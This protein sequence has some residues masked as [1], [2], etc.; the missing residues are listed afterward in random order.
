MPDG[1]RVTLG[2]GVL[3]VGDAISD[4]FTFF[5][6]QTSLG[7]GQWTVT[8]FFAGNPFGPAVEPGDFF[9]ATD[10]FV[11]FV[12]NFGEVDSITTSSVVASPAYTDA[13][14]DNQIDGTSGADVIDSGYTDAQGDSVDDGSGFGAG[15][16]GDYVRGGSGADD[17]SSGAGDDVVF[18]D[19]GNDTIDGGAGNDTLYGDG[20]VSAP[21]PQ[22]EFLDWSN[23]GGLGTDLSAGFTQTTGLMDLSVS[24]TIDGNNAPTFEVDTATN[25]TEAGEPFDTTSSLEMGG[26]GDAATS[27]TIIDFAPAT[28][29]TAEDEVQDVSF[30]I[31]DI[32]FFDGNHLDI[33][34]VD[35]FDADG[36]P[37]TVTLTPE[38]SDT[39]VGNTITADN[40]SQTPGDAEGS[41]LVE[42]AGP[43]ASIEIIYSN[44]LGGTQAINIT[45]VYFEATPIIPTEDN[46]D[47]IL[48]GTG[49]DVIL[50]GLGDDTL[51]GQGGADTITGGAGADAIF[52]NGGEDVLN[53]GDQDTARGGGGDDEFVIDPTALEG[54]AMTIIGGE[55]A[56]TDGDTLNFNGQLDTIVFDADPEN[57]TATLL[58]GTVVTFSQIENIICFTAAT[59]IRTPLG[60]RRIDTLRA[61]DMVLTADDGPQPIRWIGTKTVRASGALA[62]IHFRSGTIGNN[63]D[64][65]VSPQHRMLCTGFRAQ[66]H[67][68]QSEVLAPAKSLVNNYNVTVDYGGMVTYV[69]MLFD[70]HQIVIANGAPSESFFP[71]DSGLDA[72]EEAARAEVFQLFP[73]LRSNLGSYGPASRICVRPHEARAMAMM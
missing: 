28:P 27:T 21:T 32:D 18:G 8:G 5:T 19:A 65:L 62:P 52:G 48:G 2:D 63:R 6:I 40:T 54:G 50:G 11:Y 24:F 57:G 59:L 26:N 1:Y 41:V 31:N 58:D 4:P 3:D 64:L 49:D 37:V 46:N 51:R 45:D 56:E 44:G 73:E 70:R 20:S 33:I 60:E 66:L 12:P 22:T 53:V 16:L 36:N 23:Q 34:T 29:G 69:H 35:A 71:G 9:L 61:G 10:G 42:I 13:V 68:G 17:I 47:S 72:I 7:T 25:Y 39:V 55:N 38:G 43:V 15:G 14:T 30:R 67:F